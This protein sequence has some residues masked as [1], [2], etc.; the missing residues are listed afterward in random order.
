MTF[1]RSVLWVAVTVAGWGLTFAQ[2]VEQSSSS[3]SSV[4]VEQPSSG[5]STVAAPQQSGGESTVDKDVLDPTASL[6]SFAFRE[7]ATPNFYGR[8]GSGNAIQFQ[9]VVPFKAWGTAN[10]L[11]VTL[12]FNTGG[13][14]G[15]GL[16]DVAIFNLTVFPAWGALWPRPGGEF[17]QQSEVDN[18]QSPGWPGFRMGRQQ[19]QMDIWVV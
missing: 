7:L 5:P 2:Q 3:P 17:C 9:P 6:M 1:R 4:A 8:P 11:R 10:I 19:R 13:V 12:P 15:R 16:A 14:P 18:R